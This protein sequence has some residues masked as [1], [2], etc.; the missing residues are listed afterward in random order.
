MDFI[1]RQLHLDGEELGDYAVRSE[2]RHE[3]LAEL[4][5]LYGFR[6]FSG[7]AARELVGRG[8]VGVHVTNV[9]GSPVAT[10]PT[11]RPQMGR[12]T[13]TDDSIQD[14]VHQRACVCSPLE[15]P[16]R[17]WPPGGR[18]IPTKGGGHAGQ[19]NNGMDPHGP[20]RGAR[21]L[22][23]SRSDGGGPGCAY[24]RRRGIPDACHGAVHW[25]SRADWCHNLR[26]H[27]APRKRGPGGGEVA[28]AHGYDCDVAGVLVYIWQAMNGGPG[29][30]V[31]VEGVTLD[32]ESR[33]Y[34]RPGGKTAKRFALPGSAFGRA[35]RDGEPGTPAAFFGYRVPGPSSGTLHIAEG[36][37]DTLACAK[38][39]ARPGDHVV[40]VHGK[41][42]YRHPDVAEYARRYP[43]V[44]AWPDPGA[45]PEA[46][47]L[48]DAAPHVRVAAPIDGDLADELL[49]R[50]KRRGLPGPD[51]DDELEAWVRE[52]R[53]EAVARQDAR[54]RL[55]RLLGNGRDREEAAAAYV[56]AHAGADDDG[57]L[58]GP[59]WVLRARREPDVEMV[60]DAPG[61]AYAGRHVVCHADRGTGK[62]TYVAWMVVCLTRAGH[63][64][65]LL[66]DDDEP[67]WAGRLTAWNAVLDRIRV[68]QMSA[69]A[70]VGVL[71]QAAEGV[72]VVVLDSVRRWYRACG[73]TRRGDVNDEV[74]IGPI[75][76]RLS[77]LAHTGPAVVTLA[78]EAKHSD[79]NTARGSISLEDACEAVRRIQRD[80]DMTTISTPHK[81]RHGMPA[82]PWQVRLDDGRFTL[83]GGGDVHLDE[84]SRDERQDRIDADIRGYLMQQPNGASGRE[85]CTNVSWRTSDVRARLKAI[86]EQGSD[87]L[88]RL[89]DSGVRPESPPLGVDALDAPRPE[90]ASNLHFHCQDESDAGASR[91]ASRVSS[92]QADEVPAVTGVDGGLAT[93]E[94]SE[95]VQRGDMTGCPFP[96]LY[97]DADG[98]N[99]P[100][101]GSPLLKALLRGDRDALWSYVRDRTPANASV[102][103]LRAKVHRAA[104]PWL[105]GHPDQVA[106]ARI[107]RQLGLDTAD[108]HGGGPNVN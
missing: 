78:N 62:S 40:G 24:L 104:E 68:I 58:A 9:K 21:L 15:S 41:S 102:L 96:Q 22:D 75:A 29:G 74:I 56:A 2:T 12:L 5:R 64:V 33:S 54:C 106:A 35:P 80:G 52:H 26:F 95:R 73:A 101:L 81:S 69:A 8:S 7:G 59:D 71:E 19:E 14:A 43:T 55:T 1:G 34:R 23:P 92:G 11:V 10:G 100:T 48:A 18:L 17:V 16:H 20:V 37:I 50:A 47:A 90:G 39:Y 82:G 57:P 94:E 3:H 79:G 87:Q 65:L 89:P 6:S 67:T 97:P 76:D 51:S 86:A 93:N 31:E 27:L 60:P 36:A 61:L 72:D 105:R 28:A 70:R 84:V 98:G 88:W 103:Q 107:R 46:A 77:A 91:G 53:P 45:E 4:R 63:T 83:V 38:L 49:S 108:L 99:R 85:V 25:L 32:G 30:G 66:V 44:I 13:C 42:A